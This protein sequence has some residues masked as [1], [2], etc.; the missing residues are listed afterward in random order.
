ML[1]CISTFQPEFLYELLLLTWK[2]SWYTSHSRVLFNQNRDDA[3][4]NKQEF[5]EYANRFHNQ[6]I[7]IGISESV[8]DNIQEGAL[9]AAWWTANKKSWRF[10]QALQAKKRFDKHF[11]QVIDSGELERNL[12]KEI[13]WMCAGIGWYCINVI[14]GNHV[15]E[16]WI[17]DRTVEHCLNICPDLPRDSIRE[18]QGLS[19]DLIQRFL[20]LLEET[21]P[22]NT[23]NPED[24]DVYETKSKTLRDKLISAFKTVV[25]RDRLIS[26][27]KAAGDTAIEEFLQKPYVKVVVSAIK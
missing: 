27:L 23:V 11:E 7:E 14:K 5:E 1:I 17:A 6:G 26:A 12:A 20:R 19:T 9:N 15:E 25:E 4:R 10:C 8:L 22:T 16:K 2:A 13:K 21:Y 3:E 18:L 24:V